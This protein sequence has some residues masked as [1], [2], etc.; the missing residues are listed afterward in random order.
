MRASLRARL[1]AWL[2]LPLSLFVAVCAWLSWRNA[3]AV[4]DYVQ[5]HDLLSS[6]KVLSDRLIWEGDNVQAS[7]PPSALSLF[8]SPAHDRVFLSVVGSEGEVLAG[9]P[10]FPLPGQLALAGVDRAQWYDT[11]LDGLALRAVVT[12][13]AMYEAGGSREITIAVGFLG[14]LSNDTLMIRQF[15]LV[16]SAGMMLTFVANFTVLPL[17]LSYWPAPPR[18]LDPVPL[19]G[20]LE[21]LVAFAERAVTSTPARV[22]VVACAIALVAAVLGAGVS[23]QF[24]VYDDLRSGSAL[25]SKLRRLESK[26]RTSEIKAGRRAQ[27]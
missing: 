21:R 27:H 26:R 4:A 17:V 14:L 12:R 5:D 25:E 1:V 16:V 18:A 2:L 8:V 3:A 19:T 7:V 23:K 11:R 20:R 24:F 15:G 9:S 6:A 13:R 10:D 22:A